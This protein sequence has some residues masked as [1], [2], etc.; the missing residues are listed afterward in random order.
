MLRSNMVKSVNQIPT[1]EDYRRPLLNET[2]SQRSHRGTSS[3]N[4][5]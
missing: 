3:N 2:L 1:T 4:N 5:K